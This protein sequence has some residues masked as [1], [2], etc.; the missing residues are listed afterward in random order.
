MSFLGSRGYV[1]NFRTS[2]CRMGCS[3]NGAANDS[4]VIG[5]LSVV[6]KLVAQPN[7]KQ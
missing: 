6:T 4:R 3:G 7:E 5:C 1:D 2:C